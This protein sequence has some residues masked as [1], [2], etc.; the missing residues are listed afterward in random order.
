MSDSAGNKY[1]PPE[2]KDLRW[3]SDHRF[4]LKFL[5][6]KMC[7]YEDTFKLQKLSTNFLL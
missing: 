4:C 5:R 1:T 2:L 3:D 7:R 6:M